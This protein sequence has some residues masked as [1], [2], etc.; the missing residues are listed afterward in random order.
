[1][2]NKTIGTLG[3]IYAQDVLKSKGYT[4][5]NSN[6]HSRFGEIDIIAKKD[7][8]LVFVEVKTRHE[9]SIGTPA[10]AVNYQKQR[11]LIKTA[12]DY[13]YKNPLDLQPRFD[14]IE[15]I[16]NKSK[17]FS[18]KEYTHIENAFLVEDIYEIF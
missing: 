16:T 14:I 7:S 17:Y 8:F 12:F 5:L 9:N 2:N 3:E 4:I 13:L 15:I 10:E 1:M 6:Y 11:K 18:V